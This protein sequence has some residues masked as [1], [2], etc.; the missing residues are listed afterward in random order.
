MTLATPDQP[1]KSLWKDLANLCL[2]VLLFLAFGLAGLFVGIVYQVVIAPP[3]KL[4]VILVLVWDVLIFLACGY[5]ALLKIGA[6]VRDQGVQ[7]LLLV[8][9]VCGVIFQALLSQYK[10]SKTYNPKEVA[11]KSAVAA[12]LTVFAT[13]GLAEALYGIRAPSQGLLVFAFLF[14]CLSIL[15]RL[16]VAPSFSYITKR[17]LDFCVSFGLLACLLPVFLIIALCVLITGRPIF[18]G[19]ER[20]GHNGRVFKCYKF[21]SMVPDAQQVLEDLLAEDPEARVEW[22]REFKLKYDPRVT[23]TGRFLRKTSLDELPQLWNVLN[24]DMSLVGPRP[25][26][27]DELTKYKKSARHYLKTKPGITGVWQVSGRSDVDYE[28]RVGMDRWYAKNWTVY[29]DIAIILRTILVVMSRKGS[30]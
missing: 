7:E 3:K 21:R 23:R 2:V 8:Q 13:A 14:F 12:S 19:H 30:Y 26:T 1:R 28:T 9:V 25:V 17:L 5:L 18:F 6:D 20:V 24:G 15:L 29:S 22:E 10:F 16:F 4:T 27:A 11:Y